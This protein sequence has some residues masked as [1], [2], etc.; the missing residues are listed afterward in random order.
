MRSFAETALALLLFA[1]GAEAIARKGSCSDKYIPG[2][3][4][5]KQNRIEGR[6]YEIAKDKDF[7]DATQSCQVTDISENDEGGIRLSRN[8]Y[9]LKGG[10]EVKSLNAIKSDN[11]RGEYVIYGEDEA[12]NKYGET[13][14]SFVTT[15]YDNYMVEYVCVDIVP[16]AYYVESMSIKARTTTISET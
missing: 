6:W 2:K 10:W 7:F 16:N 13:D 8:A 3:S 12:P 14:F 4:K 11:K 15:D 9:S 1:T 5:I